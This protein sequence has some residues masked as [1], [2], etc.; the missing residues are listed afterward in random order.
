[1]IREQARSNIRKYRVFK[2]ITL[3]VWYIVTTSIII[4]VSSGLGFLVGLAGYFITQYYIIEMLFKKYITSPLH[5][6]LNAPL[7]REIIMQG[8]IFTTDA[9]WQ[10]SAEY[11]VGNYEDCILICEKKLKDNRQAKFKYTYLTYLAVCHFDRGDDE[12][13]AEVCARF[14]REIS[15]ESPKVIKR[16]SHTVSAFELYESYLAGELDACLAKVRDSVEPPIKAVSRDLITARISLLRGEKESA[17]ALFESVIDRAPDTNYAILAKHGLEAIESGVEYK[18]TFD[19]LDLSRE[20][21]VYAPSKSEKALVIVLRVIVI[22]CVTFLILT[23]IKFFKNQYEYGDALAEYRET[24][25]LAVEEEYDGVVVFDVF[26]LTSNG[27]EDGEV[28]NTCF[29]AKTDEGIIF[30][31]LYYFDGDER[32]YFRVEKNLSLSEKPESFFFDCVNSSYR[33]ECVIVTEEKDI[34]LGHVRKNM[35]TADGETY[36][37]VIKRVVLRGQEI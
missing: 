17:R 19:A 6:E 34:P 26:Y 36:Y 20:P 32:T 27:E 30:G 5:R 10:I 12:A 8:R 7:Y 31:S 28:V 4:F 1:M 24:V 15:G 16:L 25:R 14:R 9:S 18:D 3:A 11:Y 23:M 13:L 29:V 35:I 21:T 22:A 33:A 37:L 2:I